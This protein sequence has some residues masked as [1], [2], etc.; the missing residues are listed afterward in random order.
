MPALGA[1]TDMAIA[2][3]YTDVE[4]RGLASGDGCVFVLTFQ[5]DRAAPLRVFAPVRL[6]NALPLHALAALLA[7]AGQPEPRGGYAAVLCNVEEDAWG[8]V[9]GTFST[10]SGLRAIRSGVLGK[11][12][13]VLR[14]DDPRGAFYKPGPPF[15]AGN[16]ILFPVATP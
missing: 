6:S 12:A 15:G 16:V 3:V 5:P 1:S 2:G 8:P 13:T 10:A 9:R 7:S 14:V 11:R 4:V